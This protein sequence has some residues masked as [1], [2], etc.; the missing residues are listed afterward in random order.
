[1]LDGVVLAVLAVLGED[2][3]RKRLGH[4]SVY[5]ISLSALWMCLS[6]NETGK[7]ESGSGFRERASNKA[8]C[9]LLISS[10]KGRVGRNWK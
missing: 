8:Q 6:E 3:G 4:I 9:V 7:G 2:K 1:M 10:V 5:C